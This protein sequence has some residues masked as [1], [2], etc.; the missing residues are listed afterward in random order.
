LEDPDLGVA[1]AA[2]A[3]VKKL[4]GIDLGVRVGPSAADQKAA[5]DRWKAWWK[6]QSGL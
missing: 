3:A 2:R 4:T 5:A 1:S 6:K